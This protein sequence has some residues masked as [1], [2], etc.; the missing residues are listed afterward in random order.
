VLLAIGTVA[1]VTATDWPLP[2]LNSFWKEHPVVTSVVSGVVLFALAGL[3]IEAWIE[4]R[5]RQRWLSIASVAYRALANE[6]KDVRVR[7]L[8]YVEGSSSTWWEP[9]RWLAD[10]DEVF[11]SQAELQ[12][13]QGIE[14]RVAILATDARWRAMTWQGAR[15]AKRL[16]WQAIAR[17]APVVAVDTDFVGAL[18]RLANFDS[19]L[20]R[21][22]MALDSSLT[23]AHEDDVLRRWREVF[24]ESRE[25]ETSL[26]A[27]A[28]ELD[29]ASVA[30]D[31][32]AAH[33]RGEQGTQ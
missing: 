18:G 3:V 32:V 25:I 17:W 22:Q 30:T 9:D 23:D 28:R 1:A 27:A 31:V 33:A 20:A 13:A 11:A 29:T 7:L 16:N 19:T 26:L 14:A 15:Y 24:T 4:E 10:I 21:L 6:A 5:E 2:F 12:E 8:Q